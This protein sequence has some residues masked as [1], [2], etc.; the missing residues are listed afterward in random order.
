MSNPTN[1]ETYKQLKSRVAEFQKR[2]SVPEATD[3]T[4]K[5]TVSTPS[6]PDATPAKLGLTA[7]KDNAP[8]ARAWTDKDTNP[9]G[10]GENVPSVRH[11]KPVTYPGSPTEELG[12]LASRVTGVLGSIAALRGQAPV[13][14]PAVQVKAANDQVA[15]AGLEANPDFL[16][17]LASTMLATEEGVVMVSQH[18]TKQ[19]G[20]EVANAYIV[21]AL[22][23]RDGLVQAA[24]YEMAKQAAANDQVAV[25]TEMFKQASTFEQERIVKFANVHGVNLE[26][27]EEY[28]L[29]KMAYM[30][31]AADAQ[32]MF[33][34]G[35]TKRA[36]AMGPDAAAAG[37]GPEAGSPDGGMGGLPGAEGQ[38]SDE[39]VI[40]MIAQ[41]VQEGQ[42]PPEVAQQVIQ[43]ITAAS[44]GGG[45]GGAPGG[46]P[47]GGA[48]PAALAQAAAASGAGGAG[49]EKSASYNFT[50]ADLVA[51]LVQ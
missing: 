45:A 40:Q 27:R 44:Q 6:D 10:H 37:P 19:A 17:K 34:N 15:M 26:A 41:L 20:R 13:A 36:A 1:H 16:M 7:N 28:P 11:E 8:A 12:K 22:E 29:L 38:V 30:Q 39:E 2:A 42:L 3:P 18:L 43:E 35:F 51:A 14:A 9:S 25:A 23:A 31:G 24:N 49:P 5:G 50:T 48:D 21:K 32:D 47:E 46:A 4:D 33:D